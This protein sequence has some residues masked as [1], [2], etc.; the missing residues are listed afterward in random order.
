[1]LE[2]IK[3]DTARLKIFKTKKAPWYVIE[4]LLFENGYQAVVLHRIAHW[5][6]VR[7]VPFVG[8]FFHRLSIALTGVDISPGARIGPGLLISHGVG[9]VIGGYAKIGA[10]A[11]ILHGVT[12]GSPTFGR[13]EEMPVIGDGVFLGAGAQLIGGIEV[14]DGAQVGVNAVVTRNVPAGARVSAPAA[15]IR[16][17][18]NPREA[19]IGPGSEE[20]PETGEEEE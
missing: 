8:P 1:M 20:E 2:N 15:E 13:V 6:K 3:A 5:F 10:D 9:L 18:R 19:R 12:V 7:G 17:L 4:S 14:G 16:Q 11:L